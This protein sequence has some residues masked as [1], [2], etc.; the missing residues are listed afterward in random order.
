[1]CF[2]METHW[3][4]SKRPL[5]VKTVWMNGHRH[6]LLK[7]NE[8]NL[9]YTQNKSNRKNVGRTTTFPD[10]SRS[11]N[12]TEH[13]KQLQIKTVSIFLSGI[14]K[15]KE[16]GI[17]H[18]HN[19]SRKTIFKTY[20][21]DVMPTD[22][23]KLKNFNEEITF[24]KLKHYQEGVP[25]VN[26]INYFQQNNGKCN[27]E[28]NSNNI[29]YGHEKLNDSTKLI[30][31]IQYSYCDDRL[32]NSLSDRVMVWLDLA[33]Q[34][35]DGEEKLIQNKL[36]T[37]KTLHSKKRVVTAQVYSNIQRKKSAAIVKMVKRT[38]G[39]ENF[40]DKNNN[41]ILKPDS[42]ILK[43]MRINNTNSYV[44]EVTENII[45]RLEGDDMHLIKE[46]SA[47]KMHDNS[48]RQLHIFMPNLPKKSEI[49]SNCSSKISSLLSK[50]NM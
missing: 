5:F 29:A 3:E 15:F 28:I 50:K 21:I 39:E 9:D 36:N 19:N 10:S 41:E 20:T 26:R 47:H 13:S 33:A 32:I 1:M 34:N 25:P 37:Q 24:T 7:R 17:P 11:I 2:D 49:N 12:S 4:S 30:D 38:N 43:N 27:P 16:V 31:N 22:S 35:G 48:K 18:E 8:T 45:S 44:N 23:V 14:R 42:S 46:K 40:D 6:V